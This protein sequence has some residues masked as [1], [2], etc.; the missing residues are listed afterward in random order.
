VNEK[1]TGYFKL[2]NFRGI[3]VFIHWSLLAGGMLISAY[4][5]FNPTETVYFS[6]AYLSLIAIHEFGLLLIFRLALIGTYPFLRSFTDP[7]LE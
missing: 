7:C 2:L 6:L 1:R 4:V 3:P 5:G